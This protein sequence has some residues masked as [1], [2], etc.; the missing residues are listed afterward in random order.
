M[1]NFEEGVFEVYDLAKKAVF[2]W[3]IFEE[4]V[5]DDVRDY[6]WW[7]ISKKARESRARRKVLCY[8]KKQE[9]EERALERVKVFFKE[10]NIPQATQERLLR[11]LQNP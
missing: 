3:I 1:D 2:A 4:G 6:P 5:G 11:K 10:N 9:I 7:N 8:K